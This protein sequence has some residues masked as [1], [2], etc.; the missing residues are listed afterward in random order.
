MLDT[1]ITA[2]ILYIYGSAIIPTQ[3]DFILCMKSPTCQLPQVFL[4]A[5]V[6]IMVEEKQRDWAD[7]D[8]LIV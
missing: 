8:T 3:T 5:L 7:G 4:V 1:T 6:A 2:A